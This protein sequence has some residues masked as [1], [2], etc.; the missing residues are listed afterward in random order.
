MSPTY[1]AYVEPRVAL[2]DA[3]WAGSLAGLP[4]VT[5]VDLVALQATCSGA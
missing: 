2:P 5:R 1:R 4:A 3:G